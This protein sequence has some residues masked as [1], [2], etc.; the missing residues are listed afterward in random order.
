MRCSNRRVPRRAR[1]DS[2]GPAEWKRKTKKKSVCT[3]GARICGDRS[4]A[5]PH[6]AVAVFQWLLSFFNSTLSLVNTPWANKLSHIINTL[7][8]VPYVKEVTDHGICIYFGG[9]WGSRGEQHYIS[10]VWA[11]A[12]QNVT[13]FKIKSI[14]NIVIC[15]SA[16]TIS[17]SLDREMPQQ[18]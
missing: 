12:L 10:I 5:R 6:C 17:N 13:L 2:C 1:I 4:E 3:E 16:D 14:K 7:V 15:V 11:T 9:F 8:N 18:K